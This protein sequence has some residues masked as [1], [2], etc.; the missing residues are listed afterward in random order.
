MN[1]NES[2]QQRCLLKFPV[3]EGIGNPVCNRMLSNLVRMG[4]TMARG[5]SRTVMRGG[6]TKLLV[7]ELSTEQPNPFCY[8]LPAEGR[9]RLA[10]EAG[11]VSMSKFSFSGEVAI[12]DDGSDWHLSARLGAT[13]V[14][15]CV[16]SLADVKTRIDVDVLRKFVS[17]PAN[18]APGPD[19]EIPD[20][21]SLEIL[22]TE[23]DLYAIA[24]E[25]LI[26]ELPAYPRISGASL[27][28]IESCSSDFE[29]P[30][31]DEKPFAALSS[32]L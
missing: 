20:D 15:Q 14:Q 9:K 24:R 23:I 16:V 32:L 6:I 10:Q 29:T 18:F 26:L 12:S 11:A 1:R 13:V 19:C 17:D 8:F 31:F 4:G 27:G 30:T 2:V 21:D 3:F 25:L 7:A 22:A 5:R 28:E